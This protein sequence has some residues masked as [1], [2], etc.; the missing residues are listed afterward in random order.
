M[1]HDLRYGAWLIRPGIH[2]PIAAW[3]FEHEDYDGAGP[4]FRD[5]RCGHSTT[6]EGCIEQIHDHEDEEER[7]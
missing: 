6:I 2:P 5:T 7:S 4:D 3:V 1:R